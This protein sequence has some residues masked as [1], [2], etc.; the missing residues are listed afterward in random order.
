MFELGI[1]DVLIF[2]VFAIRKKVT[3]CCVGVI[4]EIK[5]QFDTIP[6]ILE[7]VDIICDGDIEPLSR[8]LGKPIVAPATNMGTVINYI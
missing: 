7:V 2:I 3:L 1:S 5:L 8:V 4:S 6:P